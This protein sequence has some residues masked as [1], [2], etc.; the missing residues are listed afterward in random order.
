VSERRCPRCGALVG[1]DARWCGQCYAALEPTPEAERPR[2]EP[3]PTGEEVAIIGGT[4]PAIRRGPDGLVWA[5]PSCG[6]AN[7]IDARAC[8]RCAT[9][10]ADL[11]GPEPARRPPPAPGRAAGLSL[12]FPGLGHVACG[13]GAEG[14]ARA[15]LFLW[16]LAF[17]VLLVTGGSGAIA[18]VGWLFLAAAAA[19]YGLTALDA[20]R[21]ASGETGQ[22]LSSRVL[23]AMMAG[24]TL[25]S[26][27][28][29]VA[30][31]LSSASG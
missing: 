10:F 3:A 21:L 17:G 9:P 22:L 16:A 24:L 11:F 29:F 28:A 20:R 18:A 12:A 15:V 6:L 19:L 25:L 2:R 1:A 14:V 5:C 23:L 27:L 4:I 7:P 30:G 26:I 13:R 31:A 8:A